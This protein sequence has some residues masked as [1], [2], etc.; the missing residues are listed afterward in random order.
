MSDRTER[1]AKGKREAVGKREE[2]AHDPAWRDAAWRAAI[3]RPLLGWFDRHARSLP[4]R[5]DPTPYK[6]WISEVMCQQ[7]QVATVV[8]YFERFVSRFPS[9]GELAAAD[10]SELLRMWE[11]LGY[12]RRARSLHAAARRIVEQHGGEFPE[13]FGDVIALPGIGRYTAGAILSISRGTR[14]PIVEGNTQRVYSRWVGLR[15]DPTA[16]P[17]N[18][19]LWEFAE[20]MLPRTDPGRFN[21][22]AME[23]GALV[24]TPR[25]PGCDACPV[26]RRCVAHRD[27]LENEIPGK[28][29]AVRYEDR[30]E[31]ALIVADARGHYLVRELPDSGRWAGMWDFPRAAAATAEEASTWLRDQIGHAVEVGPKVGSFKHAVTKYRI[32]LDVHEATIESAESFSGSAA[33]TTG[34][35]SASGSATGDINSGGTCS[36]PEPWQFVAASQLGS[37][38]M[39]VTGRKI[40]TRLARVIQGSI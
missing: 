20:T 24:C 34:P 11:G 3:R 39:S 21:Q 5:D 38:P 15:G 7:T 35:N 13:R 14:L 32:S 23:L 8:P 18:R 9:A 28:V 30:Q 36:V 4:W 37:L 2:L 16:G 33:P 26:R 1:G 17:T 27:G 31:F 22:A 19:W 25:D 40:A 29:S 12:Y 10:E 6:V